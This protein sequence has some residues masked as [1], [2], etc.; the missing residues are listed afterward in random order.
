MKPS[1][2]RFYIDGI[3]ISSI[4]VYDLRSRITIIP[5]DP[6]LFTGKFH[7]FLKKEKDI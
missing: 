3:D 7:F 2:G 4:G 1:E 5:Q 6:T